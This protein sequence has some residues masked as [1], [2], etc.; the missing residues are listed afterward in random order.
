MVW[1][2]GGC[3][4]LGEVIGVERERWLEWGGGGE[5]SVNFRSIGKVGKIKTSIN[6]H[7]LRIN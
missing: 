3:S 1:G 5:W 7:K 2:V 6:E 4:E